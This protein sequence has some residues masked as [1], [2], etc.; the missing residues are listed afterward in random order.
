MNQ[1]SQNNE[2]IE[3]DRD[4]QLPEPVQ[5]MQ[6]HSAGPKD[7]GNRN[8]KGGG[9]WKIILIIAAVI[10]TLAV[11]AMVLLQQAIGTFGKIAYENSP[12]GFADRA[13]GFFEEGFTPV[14]S[15]Q[16]TVIQVENELK[17]IGELATYKYEYTDCQDVKEVKK[18]LWDMIDLTSTMKLQYSGVIKAG[19]DLDDVDVKVS[20]ELRAIIVT[21]PLKAQILDNYV[22]IDSVEVVEAEENIFNQFEQ[23]SAVNYLENSRA[24]AL[25]KAEDDGLYEK[26][27]EHL[28]EIIEEKLNGFDYKIMFL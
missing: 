15:Q 24:E 3:Y 13:E 4:G 10:V 9:A 7:R 28:K 26:A 17:D 19:Y 1:I 5:E 25:K 18:V 11:I 22:E 6:S 14:E 12:A 16:L 2:I 21:L 23:D 8:G 27:E 20:N